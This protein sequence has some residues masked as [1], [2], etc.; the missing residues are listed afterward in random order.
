VSGG[1]FVNPPIVDPTGNI[2]PLPSPSIQPEY[3]PIDTTSVAISVF[4]SSVTTLENGKVI[5][6]KDEA[7]N[8][9]TNNITITPHL[10]ETIDGSS[11]IGITSSYGSLTLIK[12]GVDSWFVLY[13]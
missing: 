5:Y 7:G 6:I 2:T 1:I 12:N 10:S 11:S 13:R 4:L 3:W 9:T 8:A